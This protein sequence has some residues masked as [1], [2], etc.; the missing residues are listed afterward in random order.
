MASYIS[1]VKFRQICRNFSDHVSRVREPAVKSTAKMKNPSLENHGTP[2]EKHSKS[3][4]RMTSQRLK[5]IKKW[6]KDTQTN[7]SQCL[8]Q[9]S[10]RTK[11][12]Y[13]DIR[14][15]RSWT[16]VP[17]ISQIKLFFSYK[18][19]AMAENSQEFYVIICLVY[20]SHKRNSNNKMS[21]E[22]I[23]LTKPQI[24]TIVK[25]KWSP[26]NPSSLS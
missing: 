23:R 6:W 10:T 8:L 21:G 14:N 1:E 15:S 2:A 11:C 5:N 19:Y 13:W 7:H 17:C 25:A 22:D 24:G 4:I 26:Y 9:M 16:T 12:R 3:A 20:K 18:T